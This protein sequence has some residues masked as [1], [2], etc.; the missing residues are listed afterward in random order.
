MG[1]PT[2]KPV[3][4]IRR[5][6]KSLSYEG[7]IV[8]DFFAGSGTTTL[9]AIEEGRHSISSDKDSKLHGYFNQHLSHSNKKSAEDFILLE[10]NQFKEHPIFHK[11]NPL[12]SAING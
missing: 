3:E 9:V 11:E 4:I 7:S 6:I 12:K 10:E 5:I 1:H 8:L 2:Q